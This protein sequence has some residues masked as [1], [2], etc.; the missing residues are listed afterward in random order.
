MTLR[1]ERTSRRPVNTVAG[2][3]TTAH[4]LATASSAIVRKSQARAAADNGG[5]DCVSS[6]S[7]GI[8]MGVVRLSLDKRMRRARFPTST[9]FTLTLHF[10][11]EKTG[12]GEKGEKTFLFSFLSFSCWVFRHECSATVNDAVTDHGSRFSSY[13]VDGAPYH[14]ARDSRRPLGVPSRRPVTDAHT[15]G[16]HKLQCTA[17]GVT[18][19]R[20]RYRNAGASGNV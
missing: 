3:P 7:A 14:S 11:L 17:I 6:G 2:V 15:A 13:S 8:R 5:G 20:A 18:P 10:D 19:I 4:Q 1:G 16:A 9:A 12:E